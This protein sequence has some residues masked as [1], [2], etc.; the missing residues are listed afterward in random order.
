MLAAPAGVVTQAGYRFVCCICHTNPYDT[1]RNTTAAPSAVIPLASGPD[2]S[3][4]GSHDA[5]ADPQCQRE[6]VRRSLHLSYESV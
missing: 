4:A 1:S 6:L 5:G 3:G 2:A